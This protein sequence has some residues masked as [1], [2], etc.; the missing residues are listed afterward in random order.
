MN[1]K[2]SPQLV[3][4]NYN[5]APSGPPQF[6]RPTGGNNEDYRNIYNNAL[7]GYQNNSNNLRNSNNGNRPLSSVIPQQENY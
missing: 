3:E 7:Q 1:I 5:S 2:P 6:S 4:N